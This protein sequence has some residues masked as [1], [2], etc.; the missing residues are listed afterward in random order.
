MPAITLVVCLRN[1]TSNLARLLKHSAG[2]FDELLVIHDG[3]ENCPSL[4]KVRGL[5]KSSARTGPW[6]L[7]KAG[8]PPPRWAST[9][10]PSKKNQKVPRA[11][12]G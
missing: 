8:P 9:T 5:Q 10:Q 11:T 2:C 1:E 3:M 12:G 7:A 4:A 6:D